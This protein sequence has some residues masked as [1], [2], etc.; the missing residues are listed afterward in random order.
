MNSLRLNFLKDEDWAYNM[1]MMP[2]FSMCL[3][4]YLSYGPF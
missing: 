2:L 4:K 1:T 3:I